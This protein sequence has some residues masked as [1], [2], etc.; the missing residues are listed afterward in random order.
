MDDAGRQAGFAEDLVDEVVAKDGRV[1][2]LPHDNIAHEGRRTRQIP[3]DGC[4]IERT[5]GQDEAF[6]RAI[7]ESVPAADSVLGRLLL[8]ESLG[9]G[10]IE[11]PKVA[12]LGR[13]VYLGLPCILALSKHRGGHHPVAKQGSKGRRIYRCFVLSKS[14][15]LRNI[16][17]RSENGIASQASLAFTAPRM[18]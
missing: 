3:A 9:K 8:L 7:V 15:A 12:Q 13:R 10:A 14:A 5:D 11:A 6:Q 1:R 18:A 16:A 4:E 17:A 2:G